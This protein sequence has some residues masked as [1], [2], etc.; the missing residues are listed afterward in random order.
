[1]NKKAAI[2]MLRELAAYVERRQ[3]AKPKAGYD[4]SSYIHQCGAP[5]CLLGHSWA[6]NGM[7]R[8]DALE[9]Y[10]RGVP[11]VIGATYWFTSARAELFSVSG[12][13]N[14]R[15]DWRKAVGFVRA[16]CDAHEAQAT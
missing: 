16:W 1:M 9:E 13:G 8:S 3:R 14:A 12:C 7:R 10:L 11:V 6:K 4:Q 2:K 5:A 15:T